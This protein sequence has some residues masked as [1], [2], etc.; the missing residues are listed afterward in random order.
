MVAMPAMMEQ[1]HQRAGGQEQPRQC[2]EKMGTVFGEQQ[3][4]SYCREADEDPF[5][6]RC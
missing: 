3:E 1:V 6:S 4:N 5:P 2:A